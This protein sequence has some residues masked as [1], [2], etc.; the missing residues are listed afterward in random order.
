MLDLRAIHIQ[1]V[2]VT[3]IREGIQAV[4]SLPDILTAGA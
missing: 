1:M 4:L 2:L 3:G